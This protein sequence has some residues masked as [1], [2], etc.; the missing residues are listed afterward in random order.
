MHAFDVLAVDLGE[1]QPTKVPTAIALWVY[2]HS[3]LCFVQAVR[4]DGHQQLRVD[5]PEFPAM[6]T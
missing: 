4:A 6:L 3:P 5:R 2:E 1:D